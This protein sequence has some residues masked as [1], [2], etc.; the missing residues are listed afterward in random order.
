MINASVTEPTLPW[1]D[2][3]NVERWNIL[4]TIPSRTNILQAPSADNVNH[5]PCSPFKKHPTS[6]GK[7]QRDPHELQKS[8][9]KDTNLNATPRAQTS[10][11]VTLPTNDGDDFPNPR[12]PRSLKKR[13]GWTEYPSSAQQTFRKHLKLR[14]QS[15]LAKSTS[16]RCRLFELEDEQSVGTLMNKPPHNTT[17]ETSLR[18]KTCIWTATSA[19]KRCRDPPR[20]PQCTP[21]RF[22]LRA[23][24]S[25]ALRKETNH[26]P[27]QKKTW[28]PCILEI[29]QSKTVQTKTFLASPTNVHTW[30][31]SVA[32]T[33]STNPEVKHTHHHDVLMVRTTDVGKAWWNETSN[34]CG[35][36]QRS[37]THMLTTTTATPCKQQWKEKFR[38]QLVRGMNPITTNKNTMPILARTNTFNHQ[39]T[40]RYGNTALQT[41]KVVSEWHNQSF[42]EKP[43][44]KL[45]S[46][47]TLKIRLHHRYTNKN[48]MT[49]ESLRKK[50]TNRTLALHNW[51][52]IATTLASKTPRNK[53]T[54]NRRIHTPRPTE[55]QNTRN[56]RF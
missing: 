17:L 32:G 31:H 45:S 3:G 6:T 8:T 9:E 18:W 4:Q 22:K 12:Y 36:A 19:N 52:S 23:E 7:V 15:Q 53:R 56:G 26:H 37:T 30:T 46:Q 50:M 24:T 40:H 41:P 1:F 11:S 5:T 39:K 21:H 51:S 48:A 28:T 29:C 54:T 44:E 47:K 42:S 43:F 55:K 10:V 33:W 27:H 25:T 34:I 2:S 49:K 38:I 14:H 16:S 20:L 35:D 13:N